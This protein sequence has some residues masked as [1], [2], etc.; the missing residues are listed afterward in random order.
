LQCCRLETFDLDDN[1]AALRRP[2]TEMD[3]AAG[4]RLGPDR[5]APDGFR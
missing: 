4:L 1:L 5:Q 3:T 2:D